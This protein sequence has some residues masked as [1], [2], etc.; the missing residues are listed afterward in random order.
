MRV[1]LKIKIF[2]WCIQ[3]GVVPT[4]DNLVK[5]NWKGV[6]NVASL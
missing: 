3:K 4:K 5:P 6:S 1:P 2:M